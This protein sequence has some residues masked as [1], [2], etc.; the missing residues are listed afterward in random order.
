MKF[1]NMLSQ[2]FSRIV[3]KRGIIIPDHSSNN[4]QTEN[5]RLV[6]NQ[7]NHNIKIQIS[8]HSHFINLYHNNRVVYKKIIVIE[9][10]I[11]QIHNLRCYFQ[12]IRIIAEEKMISK[13]YCY[14]YH[15]IFRRSVQFCGQSFFIISNF[16][17]NQ[18]C[19]S[20]GKRENSKTNNFLLQQFFLNKREVFNYY[21]FLV[22][23]FLL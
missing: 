10:K 21:I 8:S 3:R 12:H 22:F 6:R 1:F 13:I 9:L 17:C 20:I 4:S 2:F 19:L 18:S 14:S 15:L 11:V 23:C 16:I 7:H 5:I